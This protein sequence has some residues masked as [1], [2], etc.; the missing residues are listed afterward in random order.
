MRQKTPWCRHRKPSSVKATSAIG[1]MAT[2]LCPYFFFFFLDVILTYV[3]V[4]I[5][6]PKGVIA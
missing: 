4:P 3:I 2:F 1:D 5:P 6:H